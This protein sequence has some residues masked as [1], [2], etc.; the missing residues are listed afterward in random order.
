VAFTIVEEDRS[1][2]AGLASD[3]NEP[4]IEW[5]IVVDE[6]LE[7]D[8]SWQHCCSIRLSFCCKDEELRA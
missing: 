3:E 1:G 6:I 7:L 2:L 8:V 5:D 4:F